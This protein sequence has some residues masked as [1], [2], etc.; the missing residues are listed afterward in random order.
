LIQMDAKGTINSLAQNEN[1]R[2]PIVV[3]IAIYHPEIEHL[4]AQLQSIAEQAGP[5]S[6]RLIAVI[7][8]QQSGD[9]TRKLS[10]ELGMPT[11]ILQPDNKLDAVRAFEL[12][13]KHALE[14]AN[15]CTNGTPA[16]LFALCDQDDVWD[17]NK[18]AEGLQY[19]T[20]TG[21]ALIHSDARVID[22]SGALLHNSLFHLERRRK[23]AG[24]RGLLY[25]N[26][27]TG[28]T[29]LM[30]ADVV[31]LALPFPS[32]SGVHF[33]HD[34]WLALVANVLSGGVRFLPKK[35][36]GYRQH[37]ANA[38][39]VLKR[40]PNLAGFLAGF[41]RINTHWLR[42]EIAP[43]ALARYLAHS[44]QL[45]VQ[46]SQPD[47]EPHLH[48]L[49][50]FTRFGRGSGRHLGDALLLFSQGHFSLGR[51]AAGFS[52]MNIGRLIWAVRETGKIGLG[53]ALNRFDDRIYAM[54]P[55]VPPCTPSHEPI[56]IAPPQPM[57]AIVDQRKKPRWIPEF[58][59]TSPS[60][61]VLV[62]SLNPSEAFAGIATALDIGIG[63]AQRGLNVRFVAT[64]LPIASPTASYEFLLKRM[65]PEMIKSGGGNR[66]TIGCGVTSVSLPAHPQDT[67]LATAWWTAHCAQ[68][69]I[70]EYGFGAQRFHYL[71]QDFEPM[72]YPWGQEYADAVA[73][74]DL[75]FR[76]I[77]NSSLLCDHFQSLGFGFAK[78]EVPVF[79]PS[80]DIAH[81]ANRDRIP[82]HQGPR[83]LAIY[84]RPEV[85][86]NLFGMAVEALD[87][88]L[89]DNNLS[90][91]DIETVS[92]GLKHPPIQLSNSVVM[93]S[94]GKLPWSEY[95]DYLLGTDLGLS[96]M[97]SP[98]P[99]HLPIEM[100]ASGVRVVTNNY[101]NKDL[102]HLSSAILSTEPQAIPLSKALSKAWKMAPV[103]LAERQ[104]DLSKLGAPMPL[105][106]DQLKQDFEH[107]IRM[108]EVAA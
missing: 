97:Y 93:K 76:P 104:L 22:A 49:R 98:H 6:I 89:K 84:G 80:I 20:K 75:E 67:F 107:L 38:V 32:Q 40:K 61:T 73:S 14:K 18:L 58:T 45:R 108:P 36:V 3:V 68:Y 103:E 69:L 29:T 48:P 46:T 74:Y 51:I 106:L 53:E 44:L 63:L 42:R 41:R 7:S 1:S 17:K 82:K 96:L 28:M 47:A 25:R 78:K 34:L 12:G 83:R 35:L 13:L 15:A 8:D 11:E 54:S 101:G 99:S 65:S 52:L 2:Q 94:L 91:A 79:Q 90:S 27:V 37:S 77:F 71:I 19:L 55:G 62:P 26:N 86:R 66:V 10:S 102:S 24:L 56:H 4:R 43:Y 30:R 100:A 33:Y 21:A 23:N 85:S 31:R 50:P 95:P 5:L 72:F 105:M 16:P 70:K 92:I 87:L 59:A 64:D 57:E 60:L 39:G 81:Y 9:L 88:F